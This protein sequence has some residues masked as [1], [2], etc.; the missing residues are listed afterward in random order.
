LEF[1]TLLRQTAISTGHLIP[2]GILSDRRQKKINNA[3][4]F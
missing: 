2:V 4:Q 3:A 1:V